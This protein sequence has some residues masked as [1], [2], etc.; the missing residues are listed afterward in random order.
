MKKLFFT[1]ALVLGMATLASANTYKLNN[2][3]VEAKFAASQDVTTEL[4]ALTSNTENFATLLGGDQSKGG[5]LVRAFFCGTFSIHRMYMGSNFMWLYC[6]PVVGG[7]VGFIDFCYV[8]IKGDEA[9]SK[10]A[11]NT[12]FWVLGE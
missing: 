3:S 2:A 9:L 7:T 1:L 4:N 5:F 8:L 10:Y 12:K 6:I 11:N